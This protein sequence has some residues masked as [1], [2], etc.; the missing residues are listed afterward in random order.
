MTDS[1]SRVQAEELLQ[2]SAAA[3]GRPWKNYRRVDVSYNGTWST[4]ATKLQPVLTDP[5]FR[6]AS[7]EI[8]Q[9]RDLQI[10]QV[11]RGPKGNK[12]VLRAGRRVEVSFNGT[13]SN[14][15]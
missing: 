12:R 7:T 15:P 14:D 13:R 2:T 4:V 9:P 8:Y 5:G 3:H 11:H 6:K 10:S 1:R